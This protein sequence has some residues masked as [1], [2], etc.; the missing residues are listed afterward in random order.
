[1]EVTCCIEKILY[2]KPNW[3]VAL[4]VSKKYGTVKIK[5]KNVDQLKKGEWINVDIKNILKNYNE[6]VWNL[7][8]YYH[9][10]PNEETSDK[11]GLVR[12]ISANIPGVGKK[13]AIKIVDKGIDFFIKNPE[14]LRDMVPKR[15]KDAAM[16]AWKEHYTTFELGG[17]L[18]EVNIG[19][20]KQQLLMEHCGSAYE[21]LYQIKNNPWKL[22]YQV[23]EISFEKLDLLAHVL[24]LDMMSYERYK[25]GIAYYAELLSKKTGNTIF[26]KKEFISFVENKLGV[27]QGAI[28]KALEEE[29]KLIENTLFVAVETTGDKQYLG[30]STF[31]S[32]EENIA[33]AVNRFRNNMGLHLDKNLIRAQGEKHKLDETQ[34]EALNV[35]SENA[36]AVLTGGPGTGKTTTLGAFVEAC[37]RSHKKVTLLAPTGLAMRRLSNVAKKEAFTIHSWLSRAEG[38]NTELD[39]DVIIVD[40]S[41]MISSELMGRLVRELEYR[42]ACLLLVGDKNQLPSVEPG[43]PFKDLIE[44]GNIPTIILEKIWRQKGQPIIPDIAKEIKE[45]HDPSEKPS[46]KKEATGWRMIVCDDAAK[47]EYETQVEAIRQ[48]NSFGEEN[49]VVLSPNYKNTAGV[50]NISVA[51]QRIYNPNPLDFVEGVKGYWGIGDP[52]L[53]VGNNYNIGLTHAMKGRIVNIEY[54][55]GKPEVGILWEDD[56]IRLHDITEGKIANVV[57]GYCL[58]YHRA[59]G[60]EY[61]AVTVA[62]TEYNLYTASRESLYTA[63]TRAKKEVVLVV[64]KNVLQKVLNKRASVRETALKIYLHRNW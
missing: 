28:L 24:Q 8:G 7:K 57:L 41:S 60:S 63:I 22:A 21:T 18:R 50:D 29:D 14:E 6:E 17:L 25:A 52:C 39:T 20:K 62:L 64:Q 38:G 48:H 35:L 43:A 55:N 54:T 19:P 13:R 3:G 33:H 37:T 51:L 49:A 12:Y 31:L 2:K 42:S 10:I 27:P 53:H 45:G 5:G 47:V 11:M 44:E 15:F 26:A 23:K 56:I 4:V 36:M 32:A 59:Q 58:T 40:E 16:N 1:M 46:I 9:V 61:D 30:L 34:I